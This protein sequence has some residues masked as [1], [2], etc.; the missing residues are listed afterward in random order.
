LW[1]YIR[2]AHPSDGAQA[3]ENVTEGIILPTPKTFEERERYATLA[4]DYL[5][6]T[7]PCVID[8]MDDYVES[9]YASWPDRFYL[10]GE[11]GRLVYVG[12]AGPA[13]YSPPELESA[14]RKYLGLD[15]VTSVSAASLWES[16]VAP[17]SMA[18][19]FGSGL[20][21]GTDAATSTTL[22]TSLAGASVKVKDSAGAERLAPLFFVSPRQINYLVPAETCE[23]PAVVAVAKGAD[24]L[25]KGP[26]AVKKTVPG[27]FTANADG[28]GVP[29]AFVVYV[30]ADGSQRSEPAYRFDE[31]QGRQVPAPITVDSA[32]GQVFLVLYGTG[33]RRAGT[34]SATIGGESATVSYYGPQA[35]YPGLDQ[36]NVLVPRNLAGRGEIEVLLKADGISANPVSV[37]IGR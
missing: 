32:T 1:V 26:L 30:V 6:I 34:V 3:P 13:N 27:L 22:P 5:K 28:Q 14:I 21:A 25:M 16:F 24:V 37:N 12:T 17:G 4:A 33:I 11:D 7:F 31:K 10:V 29:D 23:G 19:A 9:L 35:Q 2:E 36:V 8:S 20:A 15:A 18:V